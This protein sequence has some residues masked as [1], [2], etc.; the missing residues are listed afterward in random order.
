MDTDV[1][2]VAVDASKEITDYA[3]EWAVKN[4][5]KPMDTLILL[6]VLPLDKRFQTVEN[7]ANQWGFGQGEQR[8]IEQNVVDRSML[9]RINAVC[10]QMMRHLC[11]QYLIVQFSCLRNARLQVNTEL[12]VVEDAELGSVATEA[13]ELGATWVILDRCLKKEGDYC[14]KQLQSNIVLIDHAIPKVLRSAKPLPFKR[15]NVSRLKI[16]TALPDNIDMSP[17]HD[18]DH[19]RMKTQRAHSLESPNSIADVTFSFSSGDKDQTYKCGPSINKTKHANNFLHKNSQSPRQQVEVQHK[20][21]SFS[22]SRKEVDISPRK[23]PLSPFQHQI[24]SF[25]ESL[26]SKSSKSLIF[27]WYKTDMDQVKVAKAKPTAEALVPGRRSVDVPDFWRKSRSPINKKSQFFREEIMKSKKS[28]R[29]ES[30]SSPSIDRTSSVRKAM[31]VTI[32]KPQTPPPLC[33]ICKYNAPVFGKSPKKFSY[34]ELEMATNGFSSKNFLA[35]GGYGPVYKGVLSDGQAVAVK[36]HKM[37]SAQGA[38]EFCSEVEVLSCAQHRNL[39]MLVG[40]CIEVEWLLVYE[41]ACNGTLNSH[42]YGTETNEVMAW[43]HRMKVALG[44]ARGLRYLHEDCRVGC[45]VH[46]DF[47]PANILLTHDF[48]PLVGDFGLARWQ[49]DGQSAEETR[50]VGAFGYLAPEYI[51]TGLITEKADVYAF[52]V[53]LLELLT[54]CKATDFSRNTGQLYLTDWARPLLER[55]KVK[56]E[57]LDPRLGSIYDEKEVECMMHAASLCIS[58]QPNERPRMSKVLRILEGDMPSHLTY[59]YPKSANN[60]PNHARKTSQSSHPSQLPYSPNHMKVF[61]SS[62]SSG[63]TSQRISTSRSTKSDRKSML[64]SGQGLDH[65]DQMFSEEFQ[66]YLH[67]SLTKFIRNLNVN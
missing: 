51:H 9:Q 49:A 62:P 45:I 65:S 29:P 21:F 64:P 38:S 22:P 17:K 13:G 46:R 25:S 28:H 1:I 61:P 24:K 10:R 54:G 18:S 34:K 59:N 30:P 6:A 3:L 39:V 33:S 5:I 66:A 58:S 47:K 60:F 19:N 11:S 15:M 44:A 41:F 55:T 2:V 32:K 56:S 12:K 27:I 14:L 23:S 16:D 20:T 53:V 52:G 7:Q 26:K 43:P 63:V 48:E 40:Y 4:V 42:I 37:L 35:E 36:Q 67:G 31:S 57:I 8:P 50:I